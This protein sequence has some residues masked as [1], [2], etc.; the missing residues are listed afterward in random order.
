MESYGCA[1]HKDGGTHACSNGLTAKLPVVEARLLRRIKDDLLTPELVAEVERRYDRAVAQ[2]PKQPA[3][4]RRI[5]E[6]G[7]E[8]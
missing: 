6:L 1:T 7:A 8:V 2:Q 4:D 3:N 5:A